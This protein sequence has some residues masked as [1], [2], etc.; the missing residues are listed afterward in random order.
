MNKEEIIQAVKDM[1]VLELNEL[2]KACE[3]EFGVSAAP[4]AV[5]GAGAQGAGAAAE[6]KTEFDVI[7]KDAGSQKIKVIKAVREATGLGLKD[8]KALVDGAPKTLKEAVSKDDAEA[9]K[10]KFEEVGATLE[11]K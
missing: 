11:L 4:V 6:E 10:A 8:A 3:E 9:L 1:S 2:V 7:L 5:A